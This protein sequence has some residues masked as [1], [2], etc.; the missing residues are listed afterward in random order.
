MLVVAIFGVALVQ[1]LRGEL[2]VSRSSRPVLWADN[3]GGTFLLSNP[4]FHS[5]TK[6]MEAEY[7]F[8]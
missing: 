1:A 5:R 4:I 3:I 7:H 2:G 8:V 6:H